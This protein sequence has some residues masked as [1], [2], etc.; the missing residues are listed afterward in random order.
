VKYPF[1]LDDNKL[2]VHTFEVILR[3]IYKDSRFLEDGYQYFANDKNIC[4]T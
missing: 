4:N 3:I 2:L 1:S